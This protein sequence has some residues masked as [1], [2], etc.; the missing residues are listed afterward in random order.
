MVS[1]LIIETARG[2]RVVLRLLGDFDLVNRS[3]LE[4]ACDRIA[5]YDALQH[6]QVDMSDVGF[7]DCASLRCV[8]GLVRRRRDVGDHATI[9]VTAP[10]LR[11]L[12]DLLGYAEPGFVV[13]RLDVAA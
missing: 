3:D 9:V 13:D 5:A 6:V 10:F 11:D 1:P 7:V 4:A 12:M 2:R 8:T